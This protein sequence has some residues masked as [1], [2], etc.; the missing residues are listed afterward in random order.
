[1]SKTGEDRQRVIKA[2]HDFFGNCSAGRAVRRRRPK[3]NNE[4]FEKSIKK[5]ENES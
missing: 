2:M 3:K 5:A 4:H 1:M